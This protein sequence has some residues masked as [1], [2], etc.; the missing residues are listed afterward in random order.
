MSKRFA[1]PLL[2]S[3]TL[4]S[5]A[6]ADDDAA[7][8]AARSRFKEGVEFYDKG[9]F[10]N[11]RTAFLQAYALK[12]HPAM[13]LN[14]GQSSSRSG[15]PADA[16]KYFQQYLRESPTMTDAQRK[17]AESGLAEARAKLGRVTVN[18][19]T[20]TEITVD[21]AVVGVTPLSETIDLEPGVHTFRARYADSN[22]ESKSVS[23]TAGEKLSLNL[24]LQQASAPVVAAKP[25]PVEEPKPAIATPPTSTD[26]ATPPKDPRQ[27]WGDMPGDRSGPLSPLVNWTPFWIGAGV[28]VA[29]GALAVVMGIQ[30]SSAEDNATKVETRIRD[31]GGTKGTCSSTNPDDVARFGSACSTLRKNLDTVDTD[32]T[33]GNVAIGVGIAGAVFAAGWFLFSEKK[34]AVATNF[35]FTPVINAE[36]KGASAGFSF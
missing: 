15:H 5:S 13:L 17:D 28:A 23:V 14:L 35:H 18:A 22:N 36:I 16:A 32:A 3:L 9:Q 34:K 8:K 26:E 25:A 24:P 29:G 7:T 4:A 30:K 6:F 11:A 33:I 10:E 20:A 27:H 1:L 19:P 2:F 21:G 31:A 12:K